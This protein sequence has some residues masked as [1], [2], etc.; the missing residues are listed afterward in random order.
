MRLKSSISR[1]SVL[2]VIFALQAC[3]HPLAIEG[4]GDIVDLN[5][6]GHGC[7]LE[8][9]QA[10]DGA[11]KRN[12]VKGEYI[13]TYRAEPRP[14]WRF[15][16]W[17]GPCPPDSDF[18]QCR[19]HIAKA[20]VDWWDATHPDTD[21]PPS[22]A[23]FQPITGE[24]GYLLAGAP[25]TGVA[26]ETP[27]QQG[28]TGEDG[29]FQYE[30]GE[31]IIFRIGDTL[32][33]EVNG[34]EQVTPFE[35]AGSAV[36]TGIDIYSAL[37]DEQDPFQ[38]VVNIAVLMQSLDR[39]ANPDNGIQIS[40]GVAALF[41]GVRLDV[42]QYWESFQNESVLRRAV[43]QANM[44]QLFSTAHPIVKPAAAAEHL[45]GSL[46]IAANTV[47]LTLLQFRNE[48]EN[49]ARTERFRYDA[50]GNIIRHDDGTADAFESWQYDA[51][52]NLI[53]YE[54]D[55]VKYEN[56]IGGGARFAASFYYNANDNV[57]R[58]EIDGDLDGS[59]DD[60]QVVTWKYDR[61]QNPRYV[62]RHNGIDGDPAN[63]DFI[64]AWQYDTKGNL[65]LRREEFN[66]A[67]CRYVHFWDYDP[68]GK[69]IRHRSGCDL[70]NDGPDTVETWEYDPHGNAIRH[71][72]DSP[73]NM[74][75]TW[76]YNAQGKLTRHETGFEQ[77]GWYSL[78]T[79]RYNASG[80][81]EQINAEWSG[82]RSSGR[83]IEFWRY[84]TNGNAIRRE[85][86]REDGTLDELET[87]QYDA[88]GKVTR[89]EL[90]DG[91][92]LAQVE[93]WKYPSDVAVTRTES[94]Y[95][96]AEGTTLYQ[97]QATGWA[98]LFTHYQSEAAK[99]RFAYPISPWWL[100]YALPK[101]E[102]I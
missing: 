30:E 31:T 28:V 25:V 5:G 44:R 43:A 60:V 8:Q 42:S 24:T 92:T 32:L 33:G 84:G 13:V 4:E 94:H 29:G 97:Y 74:I 1:A 27:T 99:I 98:H 23:E 2:L 40:Q 50:G 49:L 61:N 93:T 51:N 39:D 64:G 80:N 35:L 20:A 87:W 17:H 26:Y 95:I 102:P 89:R 37:E 75:E 100:S 11:C 21:I 66:G 77:M 9:F 83:Y 65:R 12:E 56:I 85:R 58:S 78:T 82:V 55:A 16:R 6:S 48:N 18:Q 72:T 62:D 91:N 90:R 57:I 79:W 70:V 10:Q 67:D 68:R 38:T 88:T 52:G 36:V 53:R 73:L 45:Y 22:R 15:V 34:R 96:G 14:G 81:V 47:G 63:P 41:Q 71:E 19:F 76:Q 54:L 59:A 7:T 46:G 86:K 69:V 101:T 3:K